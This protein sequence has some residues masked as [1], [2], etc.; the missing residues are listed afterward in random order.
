MNFKDG[1]Y[2]AFAGRDASRALA[3]FSTDEA[4]FKDTY[5]DLSDL[6]PSELESVREWEMKF[7]EKYEVVGKLLKPGETH[8]DYSAQEATPTAPSSN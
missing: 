7:L 6:K 2:N 5:D 1:P 4:M 3:S 8:T